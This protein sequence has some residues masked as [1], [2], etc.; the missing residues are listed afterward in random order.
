MEARDKEKEIHTQRKARK[1][2]KM[3]RI[4]KSS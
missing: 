1:K 4:Q 3:K 2:K